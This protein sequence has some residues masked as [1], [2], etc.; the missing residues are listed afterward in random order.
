LTCGLCR[1]LVLVF[2]SLGGACAATAAPEITVYP[3]GQR[4]GE[5]MFVRFAPESELLRAACSWNGKSYRLLPAGGEFE[6]VLPVGL[7][8]RPGAQH[9]MIYWKY[10][11][12]G[13]GK[14]RL[15]VTVCAREF[16][17]QHLHLSREQESTYT[18]EETK[19]EKRLIGA[20]LDRVGA[21]RHW[22][23]SFVMPV[24][25][26]VST[27]FGMQRY[28]NG[29]L[30]YRH[31]GIDIAAAEGAPVRAAASGVVS[32]ADDSFILHGQ[33]VIIDHGHGIATLYIHL[34]QID[35]EDGQQ[36]SQGQVIGRVGA[37]GVAT[38]P[39]LHFG[40]YAYHE[41]VDPFFWT[42]LPEREPAE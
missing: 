36:V 41:P 24:E 39:H 11:D 23:G 10:A 38:G 37:S 29:R 4:V 33:T 22:W 40:V 16:G 3:D 12:G 9:A 28:I 35:V 18:A 30:A 2:L 25:G 8:T 7:K 17:V 19:R 6:V 21:E 26:R 27:G 42:D 34:S 5:V 15:P 1:A 20:A 31:K 13:M 14:A 32:L